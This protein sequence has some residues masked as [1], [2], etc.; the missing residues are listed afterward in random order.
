MDRPARC[1]LLLLLLYVSAEGQTSPLGTPASREALVDDLIRKTMAREA[2]SPVK[3]ARLGLDIE[4]SMRAIGVDVVAAESE[5]ELFYALV[6]L[7]NARR[8]RHLALR[9]A[10]GGL[11]FPPYYRVTSQDMPTAGIKAEADYARPDQVRFFVIDTAI[12]PGLA[13]SVR[14]GDRIVAVNGQPIEE[15]FAAAREYVRHSTEASL[16]ARFAQAIPSRTDWLPPEFYGETL[17]LTL[18]RANGTKLDVQLPYVERDEIEWRNHSHS[19][20]PGFRRE[21]RRASFDMY[22]SESGQHVLLLDWHSFGSELTSDMDW[23]VDYASRYDLLDYD[24]IVDGRR[25]S[26]GSDA[27]YVIQRLSPSPFRNTFSNLRISDVTPAYIASQRTRRDDAYTE[28]LVQEAGD[29][30]SEGAEYTD[31]IPFR[32]EYG[33]LENGGLVDPAEVHFRGSMVC[34]FGPH[35]GSTLDQF[36]AIVIDNGLCHSI[37]MPTAGY[38]NAAEWSEVVSFPGTSQPVLSFSWSVGHTI[39]PNGE[40]LE[41]NPAGVDE[42]VPLTADNYEDYTAQLLERALGHLAARER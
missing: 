16:H 32:L 5:S 31:P 34:L 2:F 7:S 41:G 23:L 37:G 3:N 36:A 15:R 33:S 28:W 14:P 1:A 20:Y 30:R 21:Y 10:P 40:L 11:K 17:R 18:E 8:D 12:N 22:R 27:P 38:S 29:S 26:G 25:S 39:R 24:I 35:G 13:T 6:R 9:P 19:T 4:A 42:Y